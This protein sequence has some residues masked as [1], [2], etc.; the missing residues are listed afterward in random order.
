MHKPR[1]SVCV[2]SETYHRK[3]QIS[4]DQDEVI[5][6]SSE[7]MRF[8]SKK[9]YNFSNGVVCDVCSRDLDVVSVIRRKE[10]QFHFNKQKFDYER[11]EL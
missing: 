4:K 6:K 2:F 7:F 8:F 1:S 10:K 11:L 3:S 5:P 9:I